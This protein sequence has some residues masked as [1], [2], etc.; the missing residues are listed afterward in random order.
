MSTYEI[1]EKT[2]QQLSETYGGQ[3]SRAT[4]AQLARSTAIF[5]KAGTLADLIARETKPGREQALALTNLEQACLWAS[6][7]IAREP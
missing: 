5:E 3:E 2:K 7:A 4:D 1:S 6:A